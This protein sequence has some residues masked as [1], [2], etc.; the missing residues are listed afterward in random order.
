MIAARERAAPSRANV[1]LSRQKRRKARDKMKFARDK[2]NL[3]R[4]RRN[5]ARGRRYLAR[6][7]G[8]LPGERET[9]TRETEPNSRGAIVKTREIFSGVRKYLRLARSVYGPNDVTGNAEQI[10]LRPDCLVFYQHRIADLLAAYEEF[11]N[12]GLL[13]CCLDTSSISV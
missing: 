3:A 13:I 9:L 2:M 6:G 11:A 10:S 12:L 4:G 5:G 1:T 8:H 7:R